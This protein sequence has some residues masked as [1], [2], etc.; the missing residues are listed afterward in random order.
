[1]PYLIERFI[2]LEPAQDLNKVEPNSRLYHLKRFYYDTAQS[3]NVIQ[4]QALKTLV[5]ASHICFGTDYPYSTMVDHADGIKNTG[6]FSAAELRQI[7]RENV[8]K[9]LPRFA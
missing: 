3:V 9:L 1:M 4:M 7:D 2:G 6:V 8:A 5:T